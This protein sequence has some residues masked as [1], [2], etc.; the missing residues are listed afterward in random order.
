MIG[1]LPPA[2]VQYQTGRSRLN[3][4]DTIFLFTDGVTEAMNDGGDFFGERALRRILTA[5]AALSP[6]ELTQAV[7][8]A[9]AAFTAGAPQS[10][11]ITALAVKWN[12][13]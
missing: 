12:P 13:R 5:G 2:E 6:R 8:G 4:G 10:D 9:V 7:L 11:D 1:L 3:P